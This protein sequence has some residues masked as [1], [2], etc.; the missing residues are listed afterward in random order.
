MRLRKSQHGMSMFNLMYVLITLAIFGYIGMKLMPIYLESIKI[1]KAVE[2]VAE[3]P[4][5]PQQ[6]QKALV[7]A[8][9]KRL[10]F[11]GVTTID[12]RNWSDYVAIVKKKNGLRISATYNAPV[13]LFY[14]ISVVAKFQF[15]G[16]ST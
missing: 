16:S 14:N 7:D 12:H 15:I 3:A 11:D 4:N 1:K 8:L 13:P 9:L 6:S 10:D 5:A 2:A